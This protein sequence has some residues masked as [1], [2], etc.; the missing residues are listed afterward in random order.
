MPRITASTIEEH[1]E[2]A[3]QSITE[4]LRELL[5]EREYDSITLGQIAAKAGVARN[6]LYNYAPDKSALVVRIA[7]RTAR[8]ILDRITAIADSA[9]P[10]ADRVRS[11]VHELIHAF[12]NS[13]F[14]LILRPMTS[15]ITPAEI[16]KDQESPFHAIPV[17]V[18]RVITD[19]IADA[20]FRKIDDIPL[21]AFLLSGVVHA[22]AIRMVE[23]QMPPDQLVTPTQ[24]LIL[25][26]L[27]SPSRG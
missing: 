13:T 3:W 26:A 5:T 2:R 23:E 22:A 24:N 18:E 7:E 20:S 4:A 12:T 27:I 16:A 21:T 9:T 17:A 15:S 14:R 19:G 1:H 8:P 11:I 25:A 6:T 10:P